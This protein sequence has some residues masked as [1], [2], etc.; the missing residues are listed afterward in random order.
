VA[1]RRRVR[2]DRA[3]RRLLKKMADTTLRDEMIAM[4]EEG[5]DTIAS[6]QRADAVS[7]RAR[8][9]ISKRVLRGS[10]RLRVGLVGRPVNRR[11]WWTKVIEGGR[12]A[13][14]VQAARR[15]P[16][17][18]ISRYAMRVSALRPRPFIFTNRV[19]ALRD[20]MGGRLRT[21][22]ERVLRKASQGVTDA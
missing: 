15:T 1:P 16:S 6:A 19:K 12:K 7:S 9:A 11:L 2:G 14:T 3:F 4:L 5:G 13:Q 18:G 20:T 21:Y 22:W 17:G 10:L 8:S